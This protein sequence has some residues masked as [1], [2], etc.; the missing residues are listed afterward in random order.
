MPGIHISRGSRPHPNRLRIGIPT[1][2]APR[3]L[4]PYRWLP[5]A[6]R[7]ERGAAASSR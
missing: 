6:L 1:A 5:R 3:A 7:A 4:V 2:N